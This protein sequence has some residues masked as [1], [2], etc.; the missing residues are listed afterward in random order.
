MFVSATVGALAASVIFS[1]ACMSRKEAM[2]KIC[3]RHLPVFRM[4][5]L[6]LMCFAL[7]G[8]AMCVTVK[9]MPHEHISTVADK[10]SNKN[11]AYVEISRNFLIVTDVEKNETKVPYKEAEIVR[12]DSARLITD[13]YES[14]LWFLTD[15]E[16]EYQILLPEIPFRVAG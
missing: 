10:L 2:T 8:A 9:L 12:S 5:L 11:G 4:F 14:H 7:I 6:A 13:T 16:K 15:I 1:C 3:G